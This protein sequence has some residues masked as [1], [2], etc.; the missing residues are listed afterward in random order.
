MPHIAV[1]R[2]RGASLETDP[3]MESI[4]KNRQ[5]PAT[6]RAMI[7]RAY[8]PDQ[9]PEGDDR[10]WVSEL[11]HG[12]FNVAYRIRLRDG[13]QVVLKIAPPAHVEVMSHERG[14][15]ATE[16]MALR[17]IRERSAV[18]VPAV[19]FADR[20][21]E[22]CDADYFFMPFVEA[23]NFGILREEGKLSTAERDA[24][25]EALGAANRELN[26][27]RGDWFGALAGP[28]EPTWRACFSRKLAQVLGDGVRRGVD[29]GYDVDVIGRATD[30]HLD[31]LD[32]VTEPRL[33]E[34]DLWDSNT[35]VRDG[36]IVCIIDH[37]RAFFGDPLMEAGFT[38]IDL[39]DGFGDPTAFIRG[40]G[41]GELTAN[42]RRRRWLYSIYLIL[43]MIIETV[44]RG[45]TTTTQYDW[46]RAQLRLLMAGSD[47]ADR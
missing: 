26:T 19:D 7:A 13:R 18:A 28:G 14:A 32:E 34:I 4:T 8:G 6:L 30:A 27:I 1:R 25:S 43:T 42:E 22:L 3:F 35:M 20:S 29:L 2:I 38:G 47:K 46:A 21:R 16:L 37:E 44:Y 12:W 5:S 41:Y 31:A 40:Y 45:H 24:Y 33:I 39:P 15:M 9:V 11:E 36:K 10:E 17:L 23:D